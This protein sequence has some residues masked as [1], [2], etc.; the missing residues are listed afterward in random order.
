MHGKFAVDIRNSKCEIWSAQF[1]QESK[2]SLGPISSKAYARNLRAILSKMGKAV[3]VLPQM[4]TRTYC[5]SVLINISI[6]GS[7]DE[8]RRSVLNILHIDGNC[9]CG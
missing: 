4:K 7:P 8:H 2:Q 5:E 6:V 3:L 1:I 9:C